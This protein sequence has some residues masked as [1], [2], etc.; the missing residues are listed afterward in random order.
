[1]R[2]RGA[3]AVLILLA[4]ALFATRVHA[5]EAAVQLQRHTER[6]ATTLADRDRE[7]AGRRQ[8]VMGIV[9]DAFD[10]EEAARRTLGHAWEERTAEERARFV[11]LFV[12]LIDRAYL[13]RLDSLDGRRIVVVEDVIDSDRA[14]VRAAVVAQDGERTPMD[15]LMRRS[16]D[17]RWRV[18]DVNVGGTSL[19]GNYRV[20][21]ARLMQSGGFPHLMDRLQAK[22]A[23]LQ[24]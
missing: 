13:R 23:S 2:F 17:G 24:P 4:L 6:L 22:V 8:E 5:G 18:V 10:F 9:T 14:T 20:Q 3:L 11:G 1:M 16:D 21:F 15:C 7:P 12:D 19:V